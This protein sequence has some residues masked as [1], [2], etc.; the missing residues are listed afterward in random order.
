MILGNA[1]KTWMENLIQALSTITPISP[2]GPCVPLIGAP[3][4]ASI[5]ALKAQIEPL[6]LSEVAFTK[7]T[8]TSTDGAGDFVVL[9]DP[10]YTISEAEQQEAAAIQN[11]ATQMIENTNTLTPAEKAAY[12][13][14]YNTATQELSNEEKVSRTTKV[15]DPTSTTN[16]Q[17]IKKFK[18]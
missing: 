11:A 8:A 4:W 1:F 6:L 10:E 3:Q 12:L 7:K 18:K 14:L 16:D 9:A 17:I 15:N 13:D 2:V 5:D